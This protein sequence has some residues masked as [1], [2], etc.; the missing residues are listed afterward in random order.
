MAGA[1]YGIL[2]K[3]FSNNDQQMVLLGPDKSST[4]TRPAGK[5]GQQQQP[6]N[7]SNFT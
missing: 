6:P 1:N 4:S 3:N 7:H 5:Q 2:S